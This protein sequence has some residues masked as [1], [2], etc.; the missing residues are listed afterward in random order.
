MSN[1]V[2]IFKQ[3]MQLSLLSLTFKKQ[4]GFLHLTCELS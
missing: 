2:V 3:L 1:T 4:I